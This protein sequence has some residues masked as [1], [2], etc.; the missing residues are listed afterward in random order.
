MIVDLLVRAFRKSKSQRSQIASSSFKPLTANSTISHNTA[1]IKP[2]SLV[3]DYSGSVRYR[4]GATPPHATQQPRRPSGLYL[5]AN[6]TNDKPELWVCLGR[7]VPSDNSF[8]TSSLLP[9]ME[10]PGAFD[11]SIHF[12]MPTHQ[13]GTFDRTIEAIPPAFLRVSTTGEVFESAAACKVRLQG[14]SLSQGFAVVVGKSNKGSFVE[15][16]CIHHSTE[17]RNHRELE[18]NVE[19]DAEGKIV[20]RRKRGDTGEPKAGLWME[21]YL[22]FQIRLF[23]RG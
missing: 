16:L 4:S 19:K 2:R 15:F 7:P 17:T 12:L 23:W 5:V 3:Y 10:I 14:F 11:R 22:F 20:S 6:P 13:R 18:Q 9:K 8:V 1:H 21:M